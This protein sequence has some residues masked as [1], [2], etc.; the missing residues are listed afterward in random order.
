M[1]PFILG[2]LTI[3]LIIPPRMVDFSI[4]IHRKYAHFGFKLHTHEKCRKLN[5]VL[6]TAH[7]TNIEGI[8][9]T[10]LEQTPRSKRLVNLLSLLTAHFNLP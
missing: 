6:A 7:P 5:M 8:I 10:F 4:A 2:L 1:K 9:G 3:P